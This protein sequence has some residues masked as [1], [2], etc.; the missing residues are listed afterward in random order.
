MMK[1]IPFILLVCG[2]I[3]LAAIQIAQECDSM[4]LK[5]ELKTK[6]KPDFKYDSSKTTRFYYK[7]KQQQKEI[8][9]P[10]YRGEKYR[11]L[12]NTAGITKQG[13]KVGIYTKPFGH[14]KRELLYQLKPEKGKHIY[15][16]EPEKSRK[17]YITYTIPEVKETYQIRDCLVLVVGYK[18][19][20][21]L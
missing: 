17:M 5:K 14:K 15:T 9:I 4:A 7:T 19:K 16:F 8:E 20:I 11:F 13:V 21:T 6:L 3:S 10:L 2:Y 18:L 12:F 1:K